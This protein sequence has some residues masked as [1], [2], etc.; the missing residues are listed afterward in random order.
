MVIR[1]SIVRLGFWGALILALT[2]IYIFS[3]DVPDVEP[4][5]SKELAMWRSR[6][7]SNVSYDLKLSLGKSSETL[8]GTVRVR[9]DLESNALQDQKPFP[10]ILDWRKIAGHEDKSR[11]LRARVNGVER[12]PRIVSE[13]LIFE[14]GTRNG[15]NIIEIDFVSPILK[16]GAAITRYIDSEDQNEYIYSLFVP[17]DASTAIPVFDQPDLKAAFGLTVT[18]PSDWKVIGNEKAVSIKAEGETVTTEFAKTKPISTYIFSFSA[19]PFELFGE[20]KVNADVSSDPPIRIFVRKSQARKFE[21]HREE[22]FRINREGIRYLEKYFDFKFPFSKYDLVLIPEFP[23]GGM[24]H[25]GST[26]IR[27]RSVIFPSEPT[28]DSIIGRASVL[29]HEAAHQWFGDTVTMRWFDD[30]WLKEGFATFMANK[31]MGEVLPDYNAWK[32]FYERTKP[33]AYATDVTKGTTPI[34]Q[35]IPNLNSAKSAY[36]NIVYQKA[37]SFLKQAEFYL[38]ESEFQAG[39]R[40]FLKSHAYANAGWEDLASAFEKSSNRDLSK[41]AEAWVGKSGVPIV[42]LTKGEMHYYPVRG[43]VH[44]TV[45]IYGLKQEDPLGQSSVWPFKTRILMRFEDG[46][47]KIEDVALSRAETDAKLGFARYTLAIPNGSRVVAREPVFVFPNYQD[48]AYGIF[49]LDPVSL[50]YALKHVGDEKDPFLRSMMWGALW[51]SVRFTELDPAVWVDLAL[52]EL[53][54][55]KDETTVSS[56]LGKLQIALQYYLEGE[57]RRGFAERSEKVL[58][59]MMSSSNSNASLISVFNAYRNIVRSKAGI[60]FLKSTLPAENE[61]KATDV[62][63]AKLRELLRTKDHF[64]TAKK[65]AAINDR[66]AGVILDKLSKQFTDDGSRRDAYSARAAFPDAKLKAEYFRDFLS[67]KDISESWIEAAASSWNVPDQ[68]DLTKPY[69]NQALSELPNLKRDRK[70]FF[71][72]GW[73]SSFIGGQTTAEAA[74]TVGDFLEKN[75]DLDIDL[76]RKVLERLDGLERAARI[77]EKYPEAKK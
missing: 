23:F 32:T 17:S 14:E 66:E 36:G 21:T 53:P 56:I 38:G 20:G 76:R 12:D 52:R 75:P 7:Y 39:V 50:D 69:L 25:A 70:I 71:V 46:T 19:G 3:M 8:S 41:W 59:R 1:D 58:Q 27:E 28:A 11:I 5:V 30:L 49:L 42:R 2:P 29:L 60:I 67:N 43:K 62:T 63:V 13:H 61:R 24:E 37:P 51:D 57:A 34:F 4:G 65:L 54:L 45:R 10:I 68:A 44:G 72:N 16:S 40:D 55:E 6:V 18:A 15:E 26:Y 48:K 74:K 31:A 77:R 22:V 47:E 35:E 33:G 9:L 64:D 73:L